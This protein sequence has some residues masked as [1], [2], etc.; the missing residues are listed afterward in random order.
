[1]IMWIWRWGVEHTHDVC[2]DELA[3]GLR[4]L[5]FIRRLTHIRVRSLLLCLSPIFFLA[6]Q[7]FHY[8]HVG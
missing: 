2:G 3:E 1:M 4:A 7:Y 8:T 5:V 6:S